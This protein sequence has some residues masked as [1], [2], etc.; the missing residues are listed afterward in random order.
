MTHLVICP[1]LLL[2]EQAQAARKR[3]AG[4][5]DQYTFIAEDAE[6][7][8]EA[9]SAPAIQHISAEEL[10]RIELAEEM[11]VQPAVMHDQ[12]G[13]QSSGISTHIAFRDCYTHKGACASACTTLQNW[14]ADLDVLQ[15][16][17]WH[18]FL[19]FLLRF[20]SAWMVNSTEA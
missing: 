10:Y 18:A 9:G 6:A 20:C 11:Q 1:M 12:S 2:Q 16:S 8:D 7:A 13:L 3:A 15:F 17:A 4:T 5:M 19:T 14:V